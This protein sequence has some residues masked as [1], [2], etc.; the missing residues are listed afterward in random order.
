MAGAYHKD[1]LTFGTDVNVII[2]AEHTPGD[3]Q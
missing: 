1:G 2:P 3:A